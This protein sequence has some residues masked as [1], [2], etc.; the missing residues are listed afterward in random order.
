MQNPDTF[1]PSDET[2]IRFSQPL[3]IVLDEYRRL[4]AAE[5]AIS[6]G[7]EE[8]TGASAYN[9]RDAM[10]KR[11]AEVERLLSWCGEQGMDAV[12][13]RTLAARYRALEQE[14]RNVA[15]GREITLHRLTMTA[16]EVLAE[17]YVAIHVSEEAIDRYEL[18]K[19]EY[20]DVLDVLD[21][22][23]GEAFDRIRAEMEEARE[24]IEARHAES[25]HAKYGQ[26]L[27]FK[28]SAMADELRA[29]MSDLLTDAILAA[30]Q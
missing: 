13:V 7:L 21:E 6:G 22:E 20:D 12:S 15:G 5:E 16:L 26:D 17:T 14:V 23:G 9:N 3:E 29:R 11:A 18:P 8:H 28:A 2:L 10:H 4:R 27:S 30:H 19:E 24:N 25:G 1:P